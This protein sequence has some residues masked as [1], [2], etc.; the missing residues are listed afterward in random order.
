MSLFEV[1]KMTT[2]VMLAGVIIA[3]VFYDEILYSLFAVFAI[4]PA[5]KL[6]KRKVV[7]RIKDEITMEFAYALDVL[8]T[9]INSGMSVEKSFEE[10]YISV[11]NMFGESSLMCKE[12]ALINKKVSLCEP[13]EKAVR[14]FAL[15]THIREI[16]DFADMLEL[17]KRTGA[18]VSKVVRN[19]H[20]IIMDKIL[21]K[22]EINTMI[23]AKKYEA[24]IMK[25]MPIVIIA[26]L[27]WGADN[28]FENLYH[29]P[30]GI[31]LMTVAIVVYFVAWV[32]LDKIADLQVD[33]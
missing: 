1:L 18:D 6:Y 9:S 16:N 20:S 8:T 3:V 19:T 21:L 33:N 26:Y 15:N 4:Y 13:V 12:I 22:E 11:K 27:R 28:Y 25:M 24:T 7:R 29:T 30:I 31:I 5:I 32:W 17:A 2:E 14:E 23:A 10:S